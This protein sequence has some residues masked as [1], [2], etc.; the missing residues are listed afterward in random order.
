MKSRF[1]K[2]MVAALLCTA[3]VVNLSI[4]CVAFGALRNEEIVIFE[5]DFERG[6][7]FWDVA[8]DWKVNNGVMISP[9]STGCNAYLK[10]RN[11]M[12]WRN[13]SMEYCFRISDANTEVTNWTGFLI[14]TNILFYFKPGQGIRILRDGKDNEFYS[15]DVKMNTDYCVKVIAKGRYISFYIKE[16]DAKSYRD[17]GT[18]KDDTEDRGTIAFRSICTQTEIEWIKLSI[19]ANEKCCFTRMGYVNM[20]ENEIDFKNEENKEITYATND[21]NI[22]TVENGKINTKNKGAFL[23]KAIDESGETVA[24]S[25]HGVC[26]E[27]QR[28]D[29]GMGAREMY[30][31]ESMDIMA[32]YNPTNTDAKK[33]YWSSSDESVIELYGTKNGNAMGAI[34]KKAGVSVVSAKLAYGGS[35]ADTARITITVKDAPKKQTTKATLAASGSKHEIPPHFYGIGM[36][37]RCAINTGEA[38]ATPYMYDVVADS[39]YKNVRIPGGGSSQRFD[40]R[41]GQESSRG[42]GG[43]FQGY[44]MEDLCSIAEQN[45]ASIVYCL[46]T[47][48]EA[49]TPEEI[50]NQ[51]TEIKK[52]TTQPLYV[53]LSNENYAAAAVYTAKWPTVKEFAADMNRYYKAIKE[54]HPDVRV[55]SVGLSKAMEKRILADPNNSVF[56]NPEDWEF[57]Q[58]GRIWD[59]NR[60][61][62]AGDCDAVTTHPYTH[63][64]KISYVTMDEYMRDHFVF[65]Q[66]YYLGLLLEN[67]DYGGKPLWLSEWGDINEI[68]MAQ[69][70][71]PTR[72]RLN[73][74]YDVGIAVTS[75][76]RILMALES[77]VVET[78][79]YHCM[80]DSSGF[81]LASEW[82]HAKKGDVVLLPRY[83]CFKEVGIYL[84]KNTHFWDIT[85]VDV[86][87][88]LEMWPWNNPQQDYYVNLPEVSAYGLGD[89]EKVNNV[90]F[91]NHTNHEVAVSVKGLKLKRNWSY[92]GEGDKAIK[93]FMVKSATASS[94]APSPEEVDLPTSYEEEFADEIIIPAFSLVFADAQGNVETVENG[95]Y[96]QL[97]KL[98]EHE[99]AHTTVLMPEKNTAFVNNRK[100][101]V[102]ENE[103]VKPVIKNGRTLV[104]LRFVAESM[105]AKV[106]FNSS[107]GAISV[108]SGENKAQFT[109]GAAT[110]SVNGEEK[111]LEAVPEI[112]SD[113]TLIPLR[114]AAEA[115]GKTVYWDDRGLIII[116]NLDTSFHEPYRDFDSAT[117]DDVIKLFDNQE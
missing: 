53:E 45:G 47:T 9:T 26:I 88:S 87:T 113:R 90:A 107:N 13:Y 7:T 35:V 72:G 32:Y 60:M 33:T 27:A 117:F 97:P 99:L 48:Q 70:D 20:G 2:R 5:D 98:T 50:V 100:T 30:V 62:G 109:L 31:G 65:N 6:G 103:S 15:M 38:F 43:T 14:R 74:N 69:T 89:A 81:G 36:G 25:L 17:C 54:A 95:V 52:H 58:A 34:A 84:D 10:F 23:L 66:D 115:I 67:R 71:N 57:T 24:A 114:A 79:S 106:D 44:K 78:M 12:N 63:Q 108:T 11:E 55:A 18:I 94:Y 77:N 82:I 105:G 91:V 22:A 116:S 3:C 46:N 61:V 41:T 80:Q 112:T 64:S 110:Y 8:P 73:T 93:D 49:F 37:D 111:T 56:A 21:E 39:K 42:Y 29:F 85:D 4:S 92:G 1:L 19:P 102:D 59:W 16:A 51:I 28:I 96:G 83:Y 104:P 68:M 75:A 40:Y 76:E 86:K 101:A